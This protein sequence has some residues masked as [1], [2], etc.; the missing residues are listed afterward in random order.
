MKA[1]N[2][3]LPITLEELRRILRQHGVIK[4]SIFGSYA[5]GDAKPGS[6]LDLLVDYADGISLFDHL[7]LKDILVKS[8][9][10]QVDLL[11]SRAVSRHFKPYIERDKV[12][13]L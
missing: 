11:S 9:G 4:A 1:D 13:I 2:L 12:T 7:E 10:K 5:R 3:S 8:S 6:D